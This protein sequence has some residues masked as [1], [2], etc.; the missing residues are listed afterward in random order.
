VTL[1]GNQAVD[2][3]GTS[4]P[5]VAVKGARIGEF[6]GGKSLSLVASSMMQIDPDIPQAH[7]YE[8]LLYNYIYHEC[9]KII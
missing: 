7:K 2:F 3:D 1:W 8:I 5:V 4:N 9:F 6:N